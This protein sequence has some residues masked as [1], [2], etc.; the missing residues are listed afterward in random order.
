MGMLTVHTKHFTAFIYGQSVRS[1][2]GMTNI[3]RMIGV[4]PQVVM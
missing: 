1:A 3:R 2:V 4:C